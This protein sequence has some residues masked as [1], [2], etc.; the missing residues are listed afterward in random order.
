[1]KRQKAQNYRI[2]RYMNKND[3]FACIVLPLEVNAVNADQIQ[4]AH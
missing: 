4:E 3:V 1:M 2:D